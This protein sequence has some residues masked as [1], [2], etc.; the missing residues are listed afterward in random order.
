M[1]SIPGLA[2][3]VVPAPKRDGAHRHRR[4]RGGSGR[5]NEDFA[6]GDS[7]PVR[8]SVR[9]SA[10]GGSKYDRVVT[11]GSP[12]RVLGIDPG[13]HV[14]GWGV[15]LRVGAALRSEGYGVVRA[16]RDAPIERRLAAVQRGVAEVVARFRPTEVAIEEVFYGRDVRAAVRIGEGRGAALVALAEAGIPVSGYANNV[17]KR[18]V[19]GAGRADK[20]RVRSM[21]RAIL[22]LDALD[23]PLDASDA[24][25]LAIC[26]HHQRGAAGADGR[27]PARGG[28]PAGR[29]HP[30][31]EA[32]IRAMRAGE[33]ARARAAAG[34]R[35]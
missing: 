23:G 13:T 17:V 35:R 10:I 33:A 26:H 27:L 15:V 1:V 32:A 2:E 29:L 5:R 11:T 7:H 25:A 20:L 21:V 8:H 16:P 12:A 31:V 19:A 4:S 18:S 30:R 28:V 6:I 24:L 3:A 22:S 14:C 34:A 9:G